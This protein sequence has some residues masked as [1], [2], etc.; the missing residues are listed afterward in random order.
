VLDQGNLLLGLETS[1]PAAVYFAVPIVV[2]V[3]AG[4][5]FARLFLPVGAGLDSTSV[6]KR[7]V[8]GGIAVAVG[9]LLVAMLGTFLV[10]RHAGGSVPAEASPD[11]LQT[12]AMATVYPLVLVSF[13]TAIDQHVRLIRGSD[14][15]DGSP[16]VDADG[17]TPSARVGDAPTGTTSPGDTLTRGVPA[18]AAPG[19]NSPAG[20]GTTAMALMAPPSF[21]WDVQ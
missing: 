5:V 17:P 15:P 14:G 13:V 16:A 2:L 4:T 19:A 18:S 3:V 12:L 1:T 6:A 20:T 10:V 11:R 7:S 21:R 9:Y 8:N